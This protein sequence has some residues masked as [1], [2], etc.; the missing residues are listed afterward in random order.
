FSLSRRPGLASGTSSGSSTGMAPASDVNAVGS[1]LL[2]TFGPLGR[3]RGWASLLANPRGL[4][5]WGARLSVGRGT[6]VTGRGAVGEGGVGQAVLVVLGEH[7][8]PRVRAARR[9]L[10]VAPHLER[11]ERLLERVVREQPTDQ[12]VAQVEQQLDR[13]ERL[14]RPDDAWQHAEHAG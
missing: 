5:E 7:D 4:V 1:K 12:R 6:S 3:V 2:V 14:D 13:L 9:A 11:V 10:G 8:G